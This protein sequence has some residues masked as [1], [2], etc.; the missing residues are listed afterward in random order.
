MSTAVE[1][2]R[3]IAVIALLVAAAALA[4]P[5]G[6][7]PI[8]LRPL[9]KALGRPA[10][11]AGAVKVSRRRRAAALALLTVATALCLWR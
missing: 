4:T 6:R 11:G 1:I 3:Q 8:A 2:V 9:A 10:D 7:L 5:P